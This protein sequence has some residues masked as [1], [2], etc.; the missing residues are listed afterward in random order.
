MGAR[1]RSI[2]DSSVLF[3]G[4]GAGAAQASHAHAD[5]FH[6]LADRVVGRECDLLIVAA[7]PRCFELER[8][9]FA[10]LVPGTQRNC[11]YPRRGRAVRDLE[12]ADDAR[13]R[14]RRRRK[15]PTGLC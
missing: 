4:I 14:I 11:E 13:D 2:N 7:L 6:I 8:L 5:K 10:A 9:V 12:R 3:D 1:P 15:P